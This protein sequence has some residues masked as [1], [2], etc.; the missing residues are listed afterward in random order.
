MITGGIG[1][2]SAFLDSTEIL[3]IAEEN[4][5][6]ASPLNPKRVGHGIGIVTINGKEKMV[7][8][9]GFDDRRTLVDEVQ[10]Y[11]VQT[12][13]WE[14]SDIKLSEPKHNFGFTSVT[15]KDIIPNF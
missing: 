15:L 14:A 2:F 13:K 9:G 3:D 5:T 12:K 4:V 11:N 10:V 8:F 6:M 7:A 1:I